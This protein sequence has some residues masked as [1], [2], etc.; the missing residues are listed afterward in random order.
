VNAKCTDKST[1]QNQWL[2]GVYK[3]AFM[4]HS[5]MLKSFSLF[6]VIVLGCNDPTQIKN[7]K[8]QP[9]MGGSD[10]E[11]AIIMRQIHKD[12]KAIRLHIK[13]ST[14]FRSI[15]PEYLQDMIGAETTDPDVKGSLFDAFAQ[16]YLNNMDALYGT[17]ED[18]KKELFNT[19]VNSCIDCH[20]EFC[21]GPIDTIE[22]LK[23]K[24]KPK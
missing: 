18:Q 23:F 16:T 22:K 14:D 15:T 8:D 2:S 4:K 3:I 19:V 11:L 7:I 5:E 21:P 12:S 6:I 17:S 20:G 9:M 10:A 1:D 13:D 24:L